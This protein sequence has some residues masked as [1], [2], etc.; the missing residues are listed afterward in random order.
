M[1]NVDVINGLSDSISIETSL[2]T[3]ISEIIDTTTLNEVF[4]S[5]DLNL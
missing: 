2:Q 3:K 5:S 1:S 4:T